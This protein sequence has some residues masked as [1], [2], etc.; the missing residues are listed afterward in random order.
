MTFDTA[1]L[2][3]D[4][5]AL[6]NHTYLNTAGLGLTPQPVTEEIQRVFGEWGAHGATT[7]SFRQETAPLVAA[8]RERAARLFCADP[9]ERA[10]TGRVA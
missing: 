4:F 10:F 1:A 8:A 2:R 6:Q 3:A 7:P 5:P 9:E